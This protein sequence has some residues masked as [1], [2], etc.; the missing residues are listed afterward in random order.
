MRIGCHFCTS[1]KPHQFP[2]KICGQHAHVHAEVH[3]EVASFPLGNEAR[4][5]VNWL[6]GA[7]FAYALMH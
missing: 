4:L 6:Y 1:V 2:S 5:K 3:A 7:K